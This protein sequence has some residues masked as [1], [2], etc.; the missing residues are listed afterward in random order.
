MGKLIFSVSSSVLEEQM[1]GVIGN[2]TQEGFY[3]ISITDDG[4]FYTHGQKFRLYKVVSNVVEGLSLQWSSSTG[5]LQLI[6]GG[7]QV[8]A[9]SAVGTI[10]GDS[11]ISATR[12]SNDAKKYT[13]THKQPDNLSAGTYG[14][15]TNLD[16]VLLPTFTIDTYGHIT[17]ISSMT[18]NTSKVKGQA[19]DEEV[20]TYKLIGVKDGTVQT[21]MYSSSIYINK[22]GSLYAST[23]FEG[24]TSL[25]NKYAAKQVATDELTGTVRLSDAINGESDAETGGTAA[26]P[27][28]VK[29]AILAA[30]QYASDLF[31]ENDALIFVG[32]IN[33][34]GVFQ[35]H[36][37]ALFPTIINGTTS[38]ANTNFNYKS[39]YTMKFTNSG[40][41]T[42][43]DQGEEV[44]F[45][46]EP[47]DVLLCVSD[48]GQTYK[49]SDFTVIQNNIDGAL[50]S[51]TALTGLLYG[52]GSRT[53]SALENPADGDRFLKFNATTEAME[54]ATPSSL[55]RT[56]YNGTTSGATINDKNIVLITDSGNGTTDPLTIAFGTSGNNATITY[57]IH[58]KAILESAAHSLTMTQG[59]TVF[60]YSPTAAAD[61]TI[62]S[63]LQLTENSDV[64]TL[65]HPVHY[66]ISTAKLGAI[67]TDAYGHVTSFS[68]VTSLPNPGNL[69]IG[70]DG[71]VLSP[72]YSGAAHIGYNFVADT[73]VTLTPIVRDTTNGLE[74]EP[75]HRS[76][77][78]D[79]KIGITHKY[80]PVSILK[81]VTDAYTE[82][83]VLTTATANTLK[84]KEGTHVTLSSTEEGI[85]TLSS[86]WRDIYVYAAS[87]SN[88]VQ[89]QLG[90]NSSLIFSQDFIVQD[91]ELAL[92]W[93]EIDASGNISYAK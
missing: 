70:T 61:L 20:D 50:V 18:V 4:Y 6:D 74:Y 27:L 3:G 51:T 8:A 31:S 39:G 64:Y 48:K 54:W 65:D 12:D 29:N 2:N 42:L 82:T 10:L 24:G 1:P 9:V 67:T 60:G 53:I 76:N 85:V 90:T 46:V 68:E 36:N 28:A 63:G 72:V 79:I 52:T 49:G 19:L 77:G 89:G 26:T 93:T 44:S 84:L 88:L 33:A 17:A 57:T 32:T 58:P 5:Q 45:N 40:T 81:W 13:I 80:R 21:P 35:S 73:D 22:D 59:A 62:G 16:A 87:G 23:L 41:I 14:N 38:V 69:Y 91:N 43:G 11:V 15:A 37:N 47:G 34:A 78:V 66:Q 30:K 25:A 7:A 71:Q 86:S 56:F 92:Y 75:G 83:S 55:W